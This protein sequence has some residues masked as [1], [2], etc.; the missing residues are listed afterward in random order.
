VVGHLEG[1]GPVAAQEIADL[2]HV[3]LDEGGRK[4]STVGY[5]AGK[6]DA[7]RAGSVIGPCQAPTA[8]YG[9][10]EEDEAQDVIE[11]GMSWLV[12]ADLVGG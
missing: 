6:E 11:L 8:V 10:L 7:L 4:G 5:G 12:G 9:V 3:G 2:V 1:L